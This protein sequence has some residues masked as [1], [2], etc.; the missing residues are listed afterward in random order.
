ML[1]NHGERR[2]VNA[3]PS[4]RLLPLV[5]IPAMLPA[6]LFP[7]LQSLH[8]PDAVL[9]GTMGVLIGLAVLGLIRITRDTRCTT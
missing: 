3:I 7:V 8:A 6:V 5:I 9:G 4:A 2:S 1:R